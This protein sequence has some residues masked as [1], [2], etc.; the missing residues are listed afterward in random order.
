MAGINHD[1]AS[2]LI[3]ITPGELESLVKSGSVRRTG[4]DDYAL[5]VLIQDY[6]GHLKS[7][8]DRSEFSP[9]QADIAA[10]LDVSDRAVR[11]F[12]EVAG[13]DHKQVSLSEIRVA[14][15]RRLRE[16]AAGRATNEGGLDLATER[17]G[18]AR[19]QREKV[20][21]QN[22][23]TRGELAPRNLLTEALA[24]TAPRICG[25][26]ESIVPALRRRSGYKAED[27]DYVAQVIADAR[28]AVA[29]MRLEEIMVG[30]DDL[31]ADE[32]DVD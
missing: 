20:E 7:E 26:L 13:I 22:A 31:D 5:P 3:G 11:E 6:I 19:A 4:R 2:R 9:K 16:I 24:R 17:A 32:E 1:T 29:A 14:Y 15:I 12:L 30:D 25:L 8:K 21:M 10:H 18:L 23:V 27:L 28:N